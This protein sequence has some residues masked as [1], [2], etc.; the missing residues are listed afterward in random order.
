[1]IVNLYYLSE[2]DARLSN[3]LNTHNKYSSAGVQTKNPLKAKLQP[4]LF[5]DVTSATK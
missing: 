5:T 2:R 4:D 3:Y 1:M